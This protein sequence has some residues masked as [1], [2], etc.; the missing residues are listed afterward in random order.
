VRAIDV[1]ILRVAAEN[2][3]SFK[4]PFVVL[5]AEFCVLAKNKEEKYGKALQEF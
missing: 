1:N 2:S 5:C 3:V 4:A